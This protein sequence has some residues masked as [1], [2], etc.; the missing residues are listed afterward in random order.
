MGEGWN[1]ETTQAGPLC[2][3]VVKG[4]LDAATA[5]DLLERMARTSGDVEVNLTA[6]TFIDSSGLAALIQAHRSL[7]GQ[8]RRLTIVEPSTAVQRVLTLSG[9]G[10][11]LGLGAGA[12]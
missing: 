3:M 8:G 10:D 2:L 9:V 6:V 11:H 1:V 7:G 4:E 12:T 5:P